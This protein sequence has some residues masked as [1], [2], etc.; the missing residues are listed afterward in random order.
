MSSIPSKRRKLD[1][2]N[3]KDESDSLGQLQPDVTLGQLDDGSRSSSEDDHESPEHD[4]STS[5]QQAPGDSLSSRPK[6]TGERALYAGGLFKS[7]MFKLQVDEMLRE[8]RPNYE[9]RLRGVDEM[10]RRLKD[11][12]EEIKDRGELSVSLKSRRSL[13]CSL[14]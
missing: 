6:D 7:S 1:H 3:S 14:C 12:I 8:V 4:T 9:K 13:Q 5:K 2:A 11:C 10:L